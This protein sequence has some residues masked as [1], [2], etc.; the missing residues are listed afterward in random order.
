MFLC[1]KSFEIREKKMNRKNNE[2]EAD[3]DDAEKG[4]IYDNDDEAEEGIEIGD[5]EDIESGSDEEWSD[6]ENELDKDLYDSK[7]DK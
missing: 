5:E 3:E 4:V 6:D 7:L 1:K 2:E